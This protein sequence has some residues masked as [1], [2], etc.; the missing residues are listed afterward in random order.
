[1][2]FSSLSSLVKKKTSAGF[3]LLQGGRVGLGRLAR[4]MA[5]LLL[6]LAAVLLLAWSAL[7]GLILPRVSD[8]RPDLEA[9]ASRALGV[10]V[11]IGQ[12]T[13]RHA[14]W[15]PSFD[16]EQVTLLD[17][18]G[19]V[20]LALP[21]V[22]LTLS[23]QSLLRLGFERMTLFHPTLNL[24]R[25][26]DGNIEV[27]GLRLASTQHDER[28]ADWLASQA[29]MAVEDGTVIWTDELQ[30]LPPVELRQVNVLIRNTPLSHSLR[31]EATPPETWG[32]R[33][34]V[35]GDFHQSLLDPHRG[36][37]QS[38]KGTAYA[39]FD[40]VD[41]QS[42]GPYLELGQHLT[43]GHGSL[44]LWADLAQGQFN[45]GILDLALSQVKVRWRDDLP[46]MDM[47][48]LQGR[49]GGHRFNGGFDLQANGLA[50]ELADGLRWP[51]GQ[52]SL[53]WE[54]AKPSRLQA[55]LG[56]AQGVLKAD[57]I[58]VAAFGALLLRVPAPVE[59]QKA[60]KTF[61]P[62]G[63][64]ESVQMSW[65]G[66][67]DPL[68]AEFKLKAQLKGGAWSPGNGMPGLQGLDAALETTQSEG[69]AKLNLTAGALDWPGN[70]DDVKLPL[71]QLQAVLKWQIEGQGQKIRL[72]IPELTLANADLKGQ[73]RLEWHTDDRQANAPLAQR[74]PGYLNLQG[75]LSRGEV[76]QVARYL[77]KSAMPETRDYLK[78]SLLGGRITQGQ[79]QVQGLLNDF[80]FKDNRGGVF[81][82]QAQ[83]KDASMDFAPA[84]GD[85][86]V[87]S[88]MAAQLDFQGQG[89]QIRASAA[90]LAGTAL[91]AAP[92]EVRIADFDHSVV[93]VNSTVK[94][95][96]NDMLKVVAKSPV[97]DWTDQVLS[98]A[99]ATGAAELKLKLSLPLEQMSRSKAQGSV[100]LA[101]N[102]FKL[103]A[104]VPR[105]TK[106][107]GSV[108]FTESNLTLA[109]LQAQA[110]GGDVKLDGAMNFKVPKLQGSQGQIRVSGA[111]SAEGLRQAPELKAFVKPLAQASGSAPYTLQISAVEGG[112]NW[113]FDSNLQGLA[114][115]LPEPFAKTA[116]MSAPLHA[117]RRLVR[118]RATGTR[119]GANPNNGGNVSPATAGWNDRL[120]L[121]WGDQ[122]ALN[123]LRD[124]SG[125]EPKVLQGRW[126]LGTPFK[127]STNALSTR[128]EDRVV[129]AQINLPKLNLDRWSQL[130][131][132]TGVTT[133]SDNGKADLTS[134][135]WNAY[136]PSQISV[137]TPV[138]VFQSRTLNN[139][140][141]SAK[142]EMAEGEKATDK[143]PLWRAKV[144]AKELAGNIEFRPASEG[145]DSTN[146]E[147]RIFARLAYLKLAKSTQAEVESLLSDPPV[148][149]PDLDIVVDST[150]LRGL[151]LGR[152]EVLALNRVNARAE[153]EWQLDRLNV[154]VPEASLAS[155][156]QWL[157]GK[158]LHQ[159][160]LNFKLDVKDA[161]KLLDRL[162]LTGQIASSHGKLEGE[163]LW[164][165]SPM[166]FDEASLG[167][168][169]KLNLENGQFL[170]TELGSAKLLSVL[171]LQSLPKRLT[172]DFRDVFSDGF[173]FDSLRGEVLIEKG[174]A[175]T[176]NLQMRG[177][178]AAV[179]MEGQVD[180]PKETQ[181]LTVVVIPEV[182]AGTAS[183][184]VAAINP[185]VGLGSFVAQYILRRPFMAAATKE[186]LID[187]T[188]TDPRVVEV[189]FKPAANSDEALGKN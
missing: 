11:Q 62:Q 95:P 157:P 51:G 127:E 30:A 63:R 61:A 4:G 181:H 152:L 20:A 92:V 58:D 1:M 75:S 108:A 126:Q 180:I 136:L 143:F 170:K 14:G 74:L 140:S 79:F 78:Q 49:M 28:V 3:S 72:Q 116:E 163:L 131:L 41:L 171:S 155:S 149:M 153:R 68:P 66:N 27:A 146:P 17:P 19:R 2:S 187:G 48:W 16:L 77:P 46:A 165:G 99:Q 80:P 139:L 39:Q 65:V 174:I 177:V 76:K 110:L 32:D 54:D 71:D 81:K 184:L 168:R 64:L 23:P 35:L 7:Y 26:T 44:R 96:L 102:E 150:E 115:D 121:K 25:T 125:P 113:Q 6:G 162:G 185:V 164:Q 93:Q 156:G 124:V 36:H 117:E 18:L 42:L 151:S 188:W 120:Q 141:L 57:Q 189:P 37:W 186:F 172:L 86:P 167:G 8:Y 137:N 144:E 182:N 134:A 31:V 34:S 67:L 10:P 128:P 173:A 94:G 103:M 160:Q 12:L 55:Q 129:S 85:W 176:R 109:N 145:K 90:K 159:T 154:T 53:H 43:Q 166:A 24:R 106:V 112:I 69:Q 15:V 40:R 45:G 84:S 98:D 21:R 132:Q 50:F 22:E 161:G 73:A 89:M 158:G 52:V 122:L 138:L 119:P 5:W 130:G 179:M 148:S 169:L 47:N 135:P 13:A 147:G 70:F 87:L 60:V 101:G 59:L 97:S 83:V 118:S 178:N 9:A 183:L 82:V 133:A 114:L 142:R 33:F 111:F 29:R 88:Q 104:E 91:V 175:N 123:Y 105:L 107:R 100:L 56:H 38:W